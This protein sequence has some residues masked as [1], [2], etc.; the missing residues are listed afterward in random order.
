MPVE[1]NSYYEIS[2]YIKTAGVE[3]GKGANIS[4]L[5]TAYSTTLFGDNDWQ[6]VSFIGQTNADQ[7]EISVAIRIGG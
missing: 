5:H 3:S 6:K 7:E 2:C 4:V 1:P